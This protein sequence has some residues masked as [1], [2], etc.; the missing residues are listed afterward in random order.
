MP[1]EKKTVTE[2]QKLRRR[3]GRFIGRNTWTQKYQAEHPDASKEEIAEV[4]KGV[5]TE[6]TKLGVRVV[7]ALEHNGYTVVPTASRE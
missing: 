3:V 5:A 6:Q 1:T 7:Q 2:E 4:W